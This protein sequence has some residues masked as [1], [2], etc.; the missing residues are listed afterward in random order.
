MFGDLDWEGSNGDQTIKKKNYK[1]IGANTNTLF[2]GVY[3]CEQK[4]WRTL[5]CGGLLKPCEH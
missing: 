5:I 3:Y 2:G 1:I 4:F